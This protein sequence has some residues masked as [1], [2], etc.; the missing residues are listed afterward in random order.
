MNP[1]RQLAHE[2]LLNRSQRGDRLTAGLRRSISFG[3]RAL[4]IPSVELDADG[5]G[6]DA[7][8]TATAQ[9]VN[10]HELVARVLEDAAQLGELVGRWNAVVEHGHANHVHASECA[11]TS[12]SDPAAVP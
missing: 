5:R 7:G 3:E 1:L 12:T 8:T 9:A 2:P 6:D 11:S 4:G 10:V